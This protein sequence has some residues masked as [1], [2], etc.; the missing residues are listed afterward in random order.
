MSQPAVRALPLVL[1][2]LAA[3]P[4]AVR[5]QLAPVGPQLALVPFG[6]AIFLGDRPAVAAGPE[7]FVLAWTI[8]QPDPEPDCCPDTGISARR[9]DLQGHA[10][11]A[12]VRADPPAPFAGRLR[13]E[14]SV[15]VGRDN[16]FVVAWHEL[17]DR[18]VHARGF[19]PRDRARTGDFVV[20]TTRD[21]WQILPKVAADPRGGYTV[22]WSTATSATRAPGPTAP[23][24]SG[25][26]SPAARS[27]ASSP[28]TRPRPR[29]G[30]RTWRSRRTA[31]GW[32]AGGP[33]CPSS[34]SAAWRAP[35]L[36]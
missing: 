5:A 22:V 36:P 26:T 8:L 32:W 28:S 14:P 33:G 16:G 29:T 24:A 30:R 12:V 18:D 4:A 3:A 13:Y 19:G 27:A 2:V 23:S 15:A 35:A 9:F 17:H 34:W 21:F 20:N 6:E 11:G 7:G 25:S 31:S 1:A 10:A